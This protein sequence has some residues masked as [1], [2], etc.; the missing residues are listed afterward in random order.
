MICKNRLYEIL[1]NHLG[2]KLSLAD[3]NILFK[4]ATDNTGNEYYTYILVYVD[5][6]LIVD[7]DPRNY[8]A[9]LDIKYTVKP[10]SIGEPKVYLGNDVGK[11]VFGGVSYAWNIISDSYVKE[12]LIC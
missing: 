2:F 3:L 9:M 7:K 4:A 8:M 1:G 5:D 10:S 11:L 6:L 12:C